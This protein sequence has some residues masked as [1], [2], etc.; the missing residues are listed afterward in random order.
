MSDACAK[1]GHP[2]RTFP[3][4]HVA[5]TN[6]KGSTSAMLER[7][8][9]EH[10][11]RTGLYTSPHL[12]RFAERIQLDGEPLEDDAFAEAL[13]VAGS[14]QLG[15]PSLFE[16]LTLAAFVTFAKA[17]V[18]VAVLEVGLGGR[19]DATNV[20]PPPLACAVTSI[21]LDHTRLLGP[22]HASIAYEKASIAKPGTPLVVGPLPEDAVEATRRTALAREAGPILWV[23]ESDETPVP[24][25]APRCY[26]TFVN[27]ST[28][29]RS[30]AT[31]TMPDGV[32]YRLEPRLDGRHQQVNAAI[33]ASVAHQLQPRFH[34][35]ERSI[36]PGIAAAR[37]PGRLETLALSGREV[38]L[39]CAH[40]AEGVATLVRSLDG[41]PPERTL[42]VYGAVEDKPWEPML[43]ALA[44]RAT[45]R[46]YCRPLEPIAGRRSVEP[47]RLAERYPGQTHAS[48]EA[49]VTAALAGAEPGELV[50][51]TGSI[52]LVGAARALLL[53]FER[54]PVVP[55]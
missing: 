19:L 20:V 28:C 41:R 15:E 32:S 12:A 38:L 16:A 54:D 22:D 46:H 18:D 48:P 8:L 33:A 2:E 43:R 23:A 29:D 17:A 34:G 35:I 49:A 14:P 1:L 51:V 42:L 7:V 4:V 53:G 26:M 9:R 36:E 39:D 21:G 45:R 25:G 50:V 3:I 13:A 37:W 6:G 47:A 44:P 5:G 27:G 11:L 24:E 40:N 30:H 31:V 10:G 52:F 55:M